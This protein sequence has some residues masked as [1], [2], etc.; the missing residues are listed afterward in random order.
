MVK[1]RRII[2]RQKGKARQDTF[3]RVTTTRTVR[4]GNK[5]TTIKET[6][7]VR[8]P[9][10]QVTVRPKTKKSSS[11]KETSKKET[12]KNNKNPDIT[13]K[14]WSVDVPSR[15]TTGRKI[16]KEIISPIK[17]SPS[18]KDSSVTIKKSRISEKE[19]QILQRPRVFRKKPQILQRPRVFRKKPQILLF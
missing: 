19:P 5:R 10:R 15:K 16:K 12:S 11:K 4:N 9:A 1:A 13:I 18:L 2:S 17:N 7:F 14:Y 3:K 8:Q 6:R